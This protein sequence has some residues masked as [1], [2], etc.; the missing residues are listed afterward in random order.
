[1][2]ISVPGFREWCKDNNLPL[3]ELNEE[4][5]RTFLTSFP[6]A[7]PDAYGKGYAVGKASAFAKAGG[8]NPYVEKNM[9][10][11]IGGKGRKGRKGKSRGRGIEG[12]PPVDDSKMRKGIEGNPPMGKPKKPTP[13]GMD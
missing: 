11:I 5:K 8:S 9:D 10:R 7:Y 4:G 12:N 13:P 3:P 1:M 2:K 6:G